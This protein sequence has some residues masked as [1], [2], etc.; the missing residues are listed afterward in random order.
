[1]LV[2]TSAAVA[3]TRS[4]KAKTAALAERLAEATPEELPVVTSYLA[5]SLLQRRTGLGWRGLS[6]LPDPAQTPTLTVAE[7][8]ETFGRISELSGAGSAKARASAVES[9]LGRA[10]A[11][12]Q[13]W[14]RGIV[15]GEVRQGALDSLVQEALAAAAGVPLVAMRRAAML[16]G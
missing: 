9:L 15:T 6:T 12:E 2:A 14:L 16:A 10:T 7:V 1:D 8:D 4:R 13:T 3:A 5:G 11:E